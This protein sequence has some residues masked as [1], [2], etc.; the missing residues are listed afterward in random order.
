MEAK[1]QL[2]DYY[3]TKYDFEVKRKIMPTE[4]LSMNGKLGYKVL[5]AQE[6]NDKKIIGLEI[7]N[8]IILFNKNNEKEELG[9]IVIRMDGVFS[10]DKSCTKKEIDQLLKVIGMAVLYGQL[11]SYITTNTA[12]SGSVSNIILPL[13]NFVE[14]SQNS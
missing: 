7:Q 5:N 4:Q 12:L 3:I 9:K 2:L 8:E 13:L 11:R 6:E 10:F 1:M 14:K